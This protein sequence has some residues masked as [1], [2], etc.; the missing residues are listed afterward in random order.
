MAFVSSPA[1]DP[2]SGLDAATC[3][4]GRWRDVLTVLLC[5]SA[6]R[7][8]LHAFLGRFASIDS[9]PAP[10]GALADRAFDFLVTIHDNTDWQG[11]RTPLG[12]TEPVSVHMVTEALKTLGPKISAARAAVHVMERVATGVAF[13]PG[14]HQVLARVTDPD[15]L[16]AAADHRPS[17]HTRADLGY[18]WRAMCLRNPHLPPRMA[19]A[20]LVEAAALPGQGRGH[21]DSPAAEG[22]FDYVHAAAPMADPGVAA[23]LVLADPDRWWSEVARTGVTRSRLSGE[24]FHDRTRDIHTV[25]GALLAEVVEDMRHHYAAGEVM[26]VGEAALVSRHPLRERL[27]WLLKYAEGPGFDTVVE[28]L[29]GYPDVTIRRK[30]AA[31]HQLPLHLVPDLLTHPD[32]EMRRGAEQ[33]LS[34]ALREA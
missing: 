2:V 8:E 26:V 20:V 13:Y 19:D 18:P 17:S 4:L 24:G 29:L 31:H 1:T 15:V 3:P 30:A 6:R 10:A 32:A 33:V 27:W 21:A 28:T 22:L 14:M 16:A 9:D 23:R 7:E 34:R 12:F 11:E 5:D 25:V